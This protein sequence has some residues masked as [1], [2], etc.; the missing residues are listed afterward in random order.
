LLIEVDLSYLEVAAIIQHNCLIIKDI[1]KRLKEKG[2][3]LLQLQGIINRH[4]LKPVL[5]A[6]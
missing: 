1:L 5:R 3:W 4:L 6:G 2:L